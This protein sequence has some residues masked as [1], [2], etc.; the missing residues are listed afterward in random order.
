MPLAL[1]LACRLSLLAGPAAGSSPDYDAAIA[2]IDR[3]NIEVN[4]DPEANYEAL[5][6]ALDQLARYA[7]QLAADS[8]GREVRLLALL[9]LVRALL[10]A[11]H[12]VGAALLMDEAIRLV[13]GGELPVARFGPTLSAFHT[14]RREALAKLGS[15]RIHVDCQQPCR[16]YLDERELALD[17]SGESQPLMF[18]SYRV[19]IEGSEPD[20]P[21][22]ERHLVDVDVD[23]EIETL[24]FPL[25]VEEPVVDEPVL[26]GP[27]RLLPR[28]AEITGLAVG[29]GLIATG[30]VLL[31]MD[32]RCPAGRDPVTD[33]A[34]CPKI[35][36]SSAGGFTTLGLGSLIGLTGGV[37]LIV[38]EVRV[39]PARGRQAL[40]GYAIRF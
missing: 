2:E 38:D 37:L 32:G 16:I 7:P 22:V 29:V 9:N 28:W 36:E 25:A 11:G 3:L 15:G 18:G 27:K 12:E 21:A 10:L 20:G 24:G 13:H 34:A 1:I 6:Q 30:G 5:G 17:E 14:D 31:G 35:Y 4:R 8:T 33:A 40:I 39:G 19:W 23:G 26:D